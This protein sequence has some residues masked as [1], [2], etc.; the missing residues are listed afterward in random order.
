VDFETALKLDQENTDYS[1]NL[2]RVREW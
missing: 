1:N 2:M